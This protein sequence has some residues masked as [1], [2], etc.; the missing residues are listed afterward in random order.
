M[1]IK[2][3]DE[4]KAAEG[5]DN[6]T[7]DQDSTIIGDEQTANVNDQADN[8]NEPKVKENPGFPAGDTGTAMLMRMNEHHKPLREW[9]FGFI[10][11]WPGMEILDVGCGG[12][13]AIHE[14]LLLS[15][16]SIVKGIDHSDESISLS[17]V[18][19][20]EAIKYERCRIEKAK[21]EHMPF[22]DREFDLVTAIETMYFW[23]DPLA[24]MR[25]I[26]RVLKRG[27]TFAVLAEACTH[28]TWAE[29]R[30]KYPG[31]FKVYTSEEI[32]DLMRS[33]GFR[34]IHAERGEGENTIVLGVK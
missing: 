12:G 28:E 19:N 3:S 25:E 15:E 34:D 29:D 13:A 18:L 5:Q 21:V 24:A 14:M 23:H 32:A 22:L 17:R 10:E 26:K 20:A 31:T 6:K 33:A 9:G 2:M 27:C 1:E 30:D 11:W 16:G 8:V 7:I 4:L